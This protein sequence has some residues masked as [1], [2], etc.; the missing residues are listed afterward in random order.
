MVVAAVGVGARVIILRNIDG[1]VAVE[2]REDRGARQVVMVDEE[3][4][5]RPPLSFADALARGDYDRPL[6]V[7]TYNRKVFRHPDGRSWNL[8]EE[9]TRPGG[10]AADQI[11]VRLRQVEAEIERL[12]AVAGPLR[13][14]AARSGALR[15]DQLNP[16]SLTVARDAWLS[17]RLADARAILRQ[18]MT[19]EQALATVQQ[20]TAEEWRRTAESG[21]A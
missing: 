2:P 19:D 21:A 14:C 13:E 1:T 20:W 16:G 12:G 6:Y 8:Y 15:A 4:M 10:M 9:Q 5:P 3:V 7:R 11:P 17:G 18:A